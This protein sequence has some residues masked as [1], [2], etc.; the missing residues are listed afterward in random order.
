L[1]CA[2][3]KLFK[4]IFK[5]FVRKILSENIRKIDRKKAIEK[6]GKEKIKNSKTIFCNKILE[7]KIERNFLE[8]FLKR[9]KDGEPPP[10]R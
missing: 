10:P 6:L 8:N 2:T 9:K 4:K 7:E 5:K 3:K 1:F